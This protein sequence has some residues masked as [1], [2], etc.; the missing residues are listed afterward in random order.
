MSLDDISIVANYIGAKMDEASL[1]IYN[2]SD[3]SQVTAFPPKTLS[4]MRS[5][6]KTLRHPM[7]GT[8]VIVTSNPFYHAMTHAIVR[9]LPF[10]NARVVKT[11][12]EAQSEI[13]KLLAAEVR[14]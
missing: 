5:F 12:P 14:A 10:L 8:F 7:T 9:M 11:M 2:I 1:P 4:V 13:D 3:L 6:Q